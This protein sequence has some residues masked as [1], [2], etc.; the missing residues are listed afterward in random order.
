MVRLCILRNLLFVFLY[1]AVPAIAGA[2]PGDDAPGI[3][4]PDMEAREGMPPPPGAAGMYPGEDGRVGQPPSRERMEKVRK[5]V[6]M[7]RMWRLTEELDLDEKTAA[8]LFPILSKYDK[9]MIKFQKN[10]FKLRRQRRAMQEGRARGTADAGELL[11]RLEKIRSSMRKL[12]D[13]KYAEL[14]K[15]LSPSQMLNYLDFEERFRREMREMLKDAR[16]KRGSRRGR[17]E[18]EGTGRD[19]QGFPPPGPDSGQ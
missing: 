4:G 16:G 9:K 11:E 7:I 19:R 14:K 17:P 15:V 5:R 12:Q 10:M 18:Y 6:E 13:E 1:L 8:R 3:P 2:Q